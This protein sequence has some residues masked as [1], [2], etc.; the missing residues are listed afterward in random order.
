[1]TKSEWK[2]F[3]HGETSFTVPTITKVADYARHFGLKLEHIVT[4]INK[5]FFEN[6]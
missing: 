4:F 6:W 3:V 2:C 5:T 1:M